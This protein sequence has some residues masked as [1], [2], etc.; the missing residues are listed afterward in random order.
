VSRIRA[1]VLASSILCAV[2]A[3]QAQVPGPARSISLAVDRTIVAA[4]ED[5]RIRVA[6]RDGNGLRRPADTFV[7]ASSNPAVMT[8]DSSGLATAVGLGV[9]IISATSTNLRATVTMQ[10]VPGRLD[11]LAPR[12]KMFV[13]E[14]LQLAASAFDVRGVPIEN[15]SVRW[16]L[17]GANGG[18]TRAAT[19]STTGLLRAAANGLI[20]ARATIVYTGVQAN[21]IPEFSGNTRVLI[22]PRIDFKLTPL[23]R[24][25]PVQRAFKIQPSYVPMGGNEQGQI[26]FVAPLDAISSGVLLYDAGRMDILTAAGAPGPQAG[27]FI[28]GFTNPSIN[29]KGQVL[30][31]V[32]CNGAWPSSGL[33]LA[34]RDSI[35]YPVL[36]GQ[37][38]G[39]IQRLINFNTTRYSINDR[40]EILFRADFQYQG[41]SVSR[42]GLFKFAD[43]YLQAVQTNDSPLPGLGPNY[44]YGF[45]GLTQ[46]G[47]VFFIASDGVR[48]ALYR[49]D[50]S[51]EPSK[52]IAT[53]DSLAASRVNT[54]ASWTGFGLSG[55]GTI[56]FHVSLADGTAV[57]ARLRAGTT[58]VEILSGLTGASDVF[59]VTQN[60]D[61]LFNGGDTNGWGLHLW[62]GQRGSNTV[63]PVLMNNVT[64]DGGN[65]WT[66][67]DAFVTRNGE[68][69]S[70]L[71]TSTNDLVVVHGA[72]ST[73]AFKAGMTVSVP[74][75]SDFLNVISGA[76]GD[77]PPMLS[78][79]GQDVSIVQWSPQGMAP[80]Y[81]TGQRM[82]ADA[83]SSWT[84]SNA[85]RN[86]AGDLYLS[87][88]AGLFRNTGGRTESLLRTQT[89]LPS[90]LSR[91]AFYKVQW[92]MGHYNG[93]NA[94]AVNSRGASVAMAQSDQGPVVVLVD[95]S[96]TSVI[97][98]LGGSAP[99]PS[100][101][102]GFFN[103]WVWG[104][105]LAIDEA[106][107]VMFGG[108][109]SNGSQGLFLYE[110]GIWQTAALANRTLI[111]GRSVLNV[112]YV[113]GANQ[114][115]FAQFGLT[116]GDTVI[117]EYAGD[118]NWKR[119]IGRGDIMPNGGDVN[120][121]WPRF[122]VNRSGDIAYVVNMN[123]GQ[124]VM[125]RTGDGTNHFVYLTSDPE[126]QI[127]RLVQFGNTSFDLR[128]DRRLY[129]T[130]IDIF[131]HN[132]LLLAEPQF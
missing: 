56:A 88:S 71:V 112:A 31:R 119:V 123:S 60:G 54:F 45:F 65:I 52:V 115:F 24:N 41:S 61:V 92:F 20:T 13:G 57:I 69:Y 5:I 127:A 70:R 62:S 3:V 37:S 22:E 68:V 34:T 100:P 44:S 67:F 33:M 120:Y 30:V 122:D 2:S 32:M 128:D 84:L 28:W 106:G 17:S 105:A 50:A 46:D 124:A 109:G 10:V 89:T 55:N 85:V 80:L 97:A 23:L 125:L 110:N 129:F 25:E 26:A 48:S 21:Q 14:E 11:V 79:G 131:D 114:S 121:V 117:A 86:P 64:I 116:G 9:S 38:L 102:G 58:S 47:T 49:M 42:S 7:W 83:F 19:I 75:N 94:L 40:G 12:D 53:S 108:I 132:T 18:I 78:A 98:A 113:Q 93:S 104:A 39:S 73:V 59:A 15:V 4:G 101:A 107:R 130:A 90:A 72:S 43:G 81:V 1:L 77:A 87:N 36:E 27:S 29:N 96:R 118:G 51:L 111:D 35:S 82:A 95:G 91:L 76:R 103:G 66:Y 74:T 126:I 63:S 6:T 8:V 16:D 99:T